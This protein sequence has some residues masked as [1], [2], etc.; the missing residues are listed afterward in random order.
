MT[1]NPIDMCAEDVMQRKLITI[2]ANETLAA[3]ERML[4]EASVSGAPVLDETGKLLGV[5]S[6]RDLMRHRAEDR[7]LPDSV[8]ATVF[9]NDI[10]DTE[11]V[12]FQR[13]SSGAC[14]A[15][16]MTQEIVSVPPSMPLPLVAQRMLDHHVHRVMVIDRQ[17]F[18][19]LV[20]ATELLGA[21]AGMA[22]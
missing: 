15:D 21:L 9:D 19:G 6:M 18:V 13:P 8:D 20:S 3:T 17:R 4:S 10:D 1:S 7:E 22:R 16:I 5:I 2:Q 14:A 12:A 11:Q